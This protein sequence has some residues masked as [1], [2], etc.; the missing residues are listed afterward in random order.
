[1][2]VTN[3]LLLLSV[4]VLTACQ[5]QVEDDLTQFMNDADHLPP[6]KIEALPQVQSYVHE[7]YNEDGLL[8]DPFVARK[9]MTKDM[10]QPDLQRPREPLEAYPLESLRFVGI[11]SRKKLIFALIQTTDNMTYQVRPGHY[12]GDK[13]GLITALEE[14]PST[15]KY[16]LTIRETIQDPDTGEWTVQMKTIE[17]QGNQS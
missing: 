13:L 12:I 7:P 6:A 16:T 3:V 11:I 10:H 2:R 14:N 17:L 15:M 8:K 4:A 1:M 9:V 5:S